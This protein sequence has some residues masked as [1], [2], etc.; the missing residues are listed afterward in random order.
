MIRYEV[1]G[2]PRIESLTMIVELP[3]VTN[4]DSPRNA[5]AAAGTVVRRYRHA[6]GD[7]EWD[8]NAEVVASFETERMNRVERRKNVSVWVYSK[9]FSKLVPFIG[10]EKLVHAIGWLVA[11]FGPWWILYR[12]A[13][14]PEGSFL[15]GWLGWPVVLFGVANSLFWVGY[16]MSRFARM[17]WD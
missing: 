10:A 15:H 6:I 11:M 16:L 3:L 7:F 4:E 5:T 12:A 2:T 14:T 17:F 1:T 9:D 8:W 13:D